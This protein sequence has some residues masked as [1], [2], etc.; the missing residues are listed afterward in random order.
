[1]NHISK[2]FTSIEG[3]I[4]KHP[5]EQSSSLETMRLIS[6]NPLLLLFLVKTSFL[7]G[8]ATV[9]HEL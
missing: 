1:M 9:I 7:S 8:T 6:V 2:N 5:Q 4:Q 3:F